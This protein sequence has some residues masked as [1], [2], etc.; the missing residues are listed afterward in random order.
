MDIIIDRLE[1]NIAVVEME[2]RSMVFIPS[3]LLPKGSKEGDVI[4]ININK[5]KTNKRKELIE[6]KCKDL[7]E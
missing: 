5:A 2:D 7:W 3:C 6:S 4:S 1:D